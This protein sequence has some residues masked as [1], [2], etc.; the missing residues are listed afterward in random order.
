MAGGLMRFIKKRKSEKNQN[1]NKS[2]LKYNISLESPGKRGTISHKLNCIT[3][4]GTMDYDYIWGE[5]TSY[6]AILVDFSF[7]LAPASQKL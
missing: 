4:R 6:S 7:C 1:F 5:I 2:L 3:T